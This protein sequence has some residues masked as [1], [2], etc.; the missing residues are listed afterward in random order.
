MEAVFFCADNQVHLRSVQKTSDDMLFKIREIVERLDK[1]IHK[2]LFHKGQ[3]DSLCERYKYVTNRLQTCTKECVTL[4]A[5]LYEMS[6]ARDRAEIELEAV[7]GQLLEKEH[8]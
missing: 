4:R 3:Y 1:A 5:R 6:K 8:E 7:C 2:N